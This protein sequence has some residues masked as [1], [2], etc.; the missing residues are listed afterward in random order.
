MEYSHHLLSSVAVCWQIGLQD[1]QETSNEVKPMHPCYCDYYNLRT[2]EYY[3]DE[4]QADLQGYI[5]RQ[6]DRQ[7][8]EWVEHWMVGWM[9]NWLEWLNGCMGG[10]MD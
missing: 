8:D 4:R 6:T 9:I 1:E 10:Q 3:I 7:T 2:S 5:D